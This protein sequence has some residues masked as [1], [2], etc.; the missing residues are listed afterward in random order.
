MP[1]LTAADRWLVIEW[2]DG[3]S[4]RHP[5]PLPARKPICEYVAMIGRTVS[6]ARRWATWRVSSDPPPIGGA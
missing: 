5:L 4:L 2:E 6:P 3:G 1:P